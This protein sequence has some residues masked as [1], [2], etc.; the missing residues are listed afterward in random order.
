MPQLHPMTIGVNDHL[1]IDAGSWQDR[2]EEDQMPHRLV[3]PP[4]TSMYRQVLSIWRKPQGTRGP[5]QIPVALLFKLSS[6]LEQW[7]RALTIRSDKMMRA[8]M[9]PLMNVRI[10]RQQA[11]HVPQFFY[12]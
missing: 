8:S 9:K 10:A 7:H 2:V 11:S 5:G 6:I 3:S 1:T 12:L 4:H